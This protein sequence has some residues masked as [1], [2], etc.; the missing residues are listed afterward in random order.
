MS[1]DPFPFSGLDPGTQA[2]AAGAGGV[3]F[4]PGYG[5]LQRNR[6]LTYWPLTGSQIMPWPPVDPPA[7]GILPTPFVGPICTILSGIDTDGDGVDD[8]IDN[9]PLT[10]NPGQEDADGDGVGDVCDNCVQNANPGQEDVDGDGVGDICDNCVQNANPGQEDAD[11]DGVGDVCDNCLSVPNANQRNTDGDAF[12]NICD[13]DFNNSGLVDLPDY[14]A[15]RSVYAK[16][17][18]GVQ[19]YVLE[20]HADLDGDGIVGLSD[21]I[22]FRSLYGKPP[23]P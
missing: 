4:V 22:R 10:P 2:G 13:A 18:P 19:P 21:Y 12:G 9:C 20:D 23:G 17:A 11:G 1:L 7:Q 5:S 3:P 15:F 6:L 14:L 16:V 8:A